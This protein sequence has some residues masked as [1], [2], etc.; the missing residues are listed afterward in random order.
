MNRTTSS[1]GDK[2]GYTTRLAASRVLKRMT[3]EKRF[4]ADDYDGRRLGVYLCW[5]C[6]FWHIG[7]ERMEPN[8]NTLIEAPSLY[9]GISHADRMELLSRQFESLLNRTAVDLARRE[10]NLRSMEAGIEKITRLI[11]KVFDQATPDAPQESN[12]AT[13]V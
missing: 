11:D 5:W 1:C 9:V 6:R 4:D 7:H 12:N 10:E 2:R 13:G 8:M 3:R